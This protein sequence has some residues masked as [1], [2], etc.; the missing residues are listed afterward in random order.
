MQRAGKVFSKD[1]YDS[2]VAD[3]LKFAKRN[4]DCDEA[5]VIHMLYS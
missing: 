1:D 3:A 2:H 5:S 4:L